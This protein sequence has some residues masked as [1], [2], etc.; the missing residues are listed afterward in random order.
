MVLYP[1]ARNLTYRSRGPCARTFSG[2]FANTIRPA[3]KTLKRL[4]DDLVGLAVDCVAAGNREDDVLER[5]HVG[6]DTTEVVANR[7]GL[8]RIDLCSGRQLPCT[9][10][11]DSCCR[12]H[13]L[14]SVE[15]RVIRVTNTGEVLREAVHVKVDYPCAVGRTVI[16]Q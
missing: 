13:H 2:P 6:I 11:G 16:A 12:T 1:Y 8:R 4:A 5:Y 14:V 15:D 3:N 7:D 10:R 9:D